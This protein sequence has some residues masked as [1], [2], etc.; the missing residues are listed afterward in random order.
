MQRSLGVCIAHY[1]GV[2]AINSSAEQL[3]AIPWYEALNMFHFPHFFGMD[4][5]GDAG[6]EHLQN[7]SAEFAMVE[8]YAPW[9]PHCQHFA[10]EVERVAAAARN[11][12]EGRKVLVG[13][14]DCV[15]YEATCNAWSI[16]GF[17]TVLFGKRSAFVNKEYKNLTAIDVYPRNAEKVSEWINNETNSS[18]D[19]S[20]VRRRDV[21]RMMHPDSATATFHG[22][23][24]ADLRSS[25]GDVWD[26]TVAAAMLIHSALGQHLFAKDGSDGA[27]STLMSFVDLLSRHFPEDGSG[28]CQHSLTDLHGLLSSSWLNFGEEAMA[29]K[30]GKAENVFVVN[31]EK[32]ES[33]WKLCKKDWSQYTS[34]WRACKGTYPGKRGY[35]CG[36]WSMFHGLAA[37]SSDATAGRDLRTLRDT[38]GHF[39]DCDECRDHFLTIPLPE[40][41][42]TRKESQ[43][44][45]WNA[46]NVVNARVAKLED[47]F[48][49][50]DPRF[51]KVQWP[52]RELCPKCRKGRSFL[53]LTPE[54]KPERVGRDT[55]SVGQAGDVNFEYLT[56]KEAMEQEGWQLDEVIE[57]LSGFYGDKN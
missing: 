37:R 45:W 52:T 35:T 28:S 4:L 39:F 1:V 49:D 42:V 34:G 31:T 26:M 15:K 19:V 16:Q 12:H 36:L 47:Q 11:Y 44:W 56:V 50:G 20:A 8:F 2:V 18:L 40:G 10:P 57:F 41:S 25:G 55:N 38:I 51:P 53:Q 3:P 14:V 13:T 48:E 46:H 54:T 23:T 29:E 9:C 32:V 6:L 17:P 5:D 33:Q 43:L 21:L 22:P 24:V 7:A 30:D 27:Q